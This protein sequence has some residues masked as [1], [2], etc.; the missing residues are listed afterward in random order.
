MVEIILWGSQKQGESEWDTEVFKLGR[1][2][3]QGCPLSAILYSISA[4]PLATMVKQDKR[5]LSV[6]IP[7]GR[8][9]L[10]YQ[11]ADDTNFTVKNI[12]CELRD[13]GFEDL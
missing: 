4:E 9:S 10:I 2:I 8:S 5:I 7:F 1:S 6:D 3:R 11:F 12:E 13:R